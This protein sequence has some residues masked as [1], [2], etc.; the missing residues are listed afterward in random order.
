[1]EF[2]VVTYCTPHLLWHPYYE[3]TDK[4]GGKQK[5]MIPCFSVLIKQ[6]KSIKCLHCIGKIN[7]V[8]FVCRITLEKAQL[9]P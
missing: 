4:T 9:Q 1:M 7:Q 8:G 3:G 6:L 2:N 5:S